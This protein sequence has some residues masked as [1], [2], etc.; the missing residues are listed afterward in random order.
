MGVRF[1]LANDDVEFIIRTTLSEIFTG[2]RGKRL[3]LAE[4]L[5]ARAGR[6][7]SLSLLNAYSSTTSSTARFPASLILPLGE[8]TEDDRLQR[9][10]MGPRLRQLV[11]FAEAELWSVRN[12]REREALRETLLGELQPRGRR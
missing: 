3:Q 5:S 12:Q 11:E 9:L 2:Y 10:V 6:L 8:I 7:I 4:A 1:H